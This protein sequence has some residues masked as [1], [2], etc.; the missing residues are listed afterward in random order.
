MRL[1][2]LLIRVH[3]ANISLYS[4]IQLLDELS[5]HAQEPQA[6][7]LRDFLSSAMPAV[8]DN[9]NQLFSQMSLYQPAADRY[10]ALVNAPP[11]PT[12]MPL[13]LTDTAIAA[14]QLSE[15]T[16]QLPNGAGAA[17]KFDLVK[18][19]ND[20]ANY[21]ITVSTGRKEICVWDVHT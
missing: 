17:G 12:L 16:A 19:F 18:R 13:V 7:F 11:F 5:A 1:I 15:S 10:P 3:S 2:I 21:V 14:S 4:F 20:D 9:G 6:L 8:M